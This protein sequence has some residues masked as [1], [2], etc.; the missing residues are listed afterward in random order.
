MCT[1]EGELAK[2]RKV[3]VC[4]GE[5]SFSGLSPDAV[6][7]LSV[8]E[9][10]SC[11]WTPG[12]VREAVPVDSELSLVLMQVSSCLKRVLPRHC[13]ECGGGVLLGVFLWGQYCL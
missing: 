6:K 13:C 11:E 1:L 8:D 10:S 3:G 7:V 4:G 2:V 12:G 9:G 5:S